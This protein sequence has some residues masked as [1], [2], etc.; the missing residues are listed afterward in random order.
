MK[1]NHKIALL[2]I[3]PAILFG[4]F[5]MADMFTTSESNVP[6]ADATPAIDTTIVDTTSQQERIIVNDNV[7]YTVNEDGTK[8]FSAEF[9]ENLGLEDYV[10][11][12]IP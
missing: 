2:A 5:F 4:G 12:S 9:T 7:S 3:V 11:A 10:E 1:R 8:N 6:V